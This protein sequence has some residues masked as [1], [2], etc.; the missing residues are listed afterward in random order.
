MATTREVSFN[1]TR[2]EAR[3]I[4]KIAGRAFEM[5]R[6][7]GSKR[8]FI[9]IEMDVTATHANGCRLDLD[10]ML[11]ADDFNF[12]HDVGGITRHLNRETGKLEHCFMP[13]FA[14][15]KAA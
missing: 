15:R 3:T 5:F 7:V 10:R 8:A 11:V 6:S 2:D 14:E 12:S 13:R 1:V 4:S 9:D